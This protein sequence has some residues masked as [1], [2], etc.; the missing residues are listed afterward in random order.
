MQVILFLFFIL[1]PRDTMLIF[2]SPDCPHCMEILKEIIQKPPPVPYK[3]LNIEK[4]SCIT[5][6]SQIERKLDTFGNDLP[7]VYFK[8]KLY[9][10]NL[11]FRYFSSPKRQKTPPIYSRECKNCDKEKFKKSNTTPE[12]PVLLYAPGCRHCNSFEL[13][14][15]RLLKNDTIRY[16]AV[17]TFSEE[18]IS[19]I[20]SLKKRGL[21]RGV[22]LLLI[23][24][25]VLYH[26]PQRKEEFIAI[27]KAHKEA[28]SF[29]S[30][31]KKINFAPTLFATIFAGLIDGI[32]PCAFTVLLF[33]IA[34]VSYRGTEK[35]KSILIL[36]FYS[37]GIFIAYF[38]IGIGLF[39]VLELIN[40]VSYLNMALRLL[41][42]G[43]ALI[44]GIISFYEA[45]TIDPRKPH[46]FLALSQNQ[47][48]K[49]HKIIKKY[50][51]EGLVAGSFLTGLS[52]SFVEFACTGQI[53]LPTLSYIAHKKGV[54]VERLAYLLL[55]NI[56]FLL[57][58][59][60][61]GLL[62]IFIEQRVVSKKLS[63]KI[64]EIK[65]AT[66]LVFLLLFILVVFA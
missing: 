17:S 23:G 6:L 45:F 1:A 48:V 65:I 59:L 7:V 2:Y 56:F 11:P 51:G 24:D 39:W 19:I 20:E 9:Y 21:Y 44:L 14:L 37:L 33:L 15:K 52:I 61:I 13:R 58:L 16:V 28:A 35:K 34:F 55:Y 38:S 63:A 4:D 32:N 26:L 42:G 29:I 64:K 3:L 60:G 8:G 47:K 5:L 50:A 62:A 30:R 46:S 66:G 12:L 36:V 43:V 27:L 31:E 49:T 18:G 57:P 22:P 10:G 40:R 41:I 54:T 53:Y 25:T